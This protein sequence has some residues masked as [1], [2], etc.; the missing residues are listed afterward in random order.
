MNAL[1]QFRA[2]GLGNMTATRAQRNAA[3]EEVAS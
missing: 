2:N 1:L 3:A